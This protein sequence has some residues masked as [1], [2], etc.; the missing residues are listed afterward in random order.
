MCTHAAEVALFNHPSKVH[1]HFSLVNTLGLLFMTLGR[2]LS[3]ICLSVCMAC[4]LDVTWTTTD[5]IIMAIIITVVRAVLLL[6]VLAHWPKTTAFVQRQPYKTD[7]VRVHSVRRVCTR[8]TEQQLDTLLPFFSSD[9]S[10]QGV[11]ANSYCWTAKKHKY[12]FAFSSCYTKM[13][14][15]VYFLLL[16]SCWLTAR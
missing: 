10:L 9:G 4:L 11:L 8:H 2:M 16:K 7:S 6:S 15:C 5:T 12:T 1:T 3:A 14:I 13:S